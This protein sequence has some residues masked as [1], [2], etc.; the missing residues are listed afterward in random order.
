MRGGYHPVGLWRQLVSGDFCHSAGDDATEASGPPHAPVCLGQGWLDTL[1]LPEIWP[2]ACRKCSVR[3]VDFRPKFG[4]WLVGPYYGFRLALPANQAHTRG[5]GCERH[6]QAITDH[7]PESGRYEKFVG[8]NNQ[9]KSSHRPVFAQNSAYGFKEAMWRIL[10]KIMVIR[11]IH[12]R[13]GEL[14]DQQPKFLRPCKKSDFRPLTAPLQ[15]N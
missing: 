2:S 11:F 10:G 3:S 6:H 7:M 9:R 14:T 12:Q 15:T 8:P 5:I 13:P 1:F 4:L